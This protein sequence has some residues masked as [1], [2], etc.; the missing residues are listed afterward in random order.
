MRACFGPLAHVYLHLR[1]PEI[2]PRFLCFLV[3]G[4]VT[5]RHI[6]VLSP[7]RVASLFFRRAFTGERQ[8]CSYW[9]CGGVERQQT[10][11]PWNQDTYT[12]E[13]TVGRA[14]RRGSAVLD[15]EKNM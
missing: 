12:E 9:F 2:G 10:L 6:P 7:T 11:E 4:N 14:F 13:K 1:P 8:T 5:T 15:A 3:F